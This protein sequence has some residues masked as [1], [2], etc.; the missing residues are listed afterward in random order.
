MNFP[1]EQLINFII[2]FQ[3]FL[4]ELLFAVRYP[5]YE[6]HQMPARRQSNQP[7]IAS[8]QTQTNYK[9]HPPFGLLSKK[10]GDTHFGD[11]LQR[12][13]NILGKNDDFRRFQKA[14]SNMLR[15]KNVDDNEK[16]TSTDCGLVVKNYKEKHMRRNEVTDE[17]EVD[18][19]KD[20]DRKIQHL[21]RIRTFRKFQKALDSVMNSDN[22]DSGIGGDIEPIKRRVNGTDHDDSNDE[23]S[24]EH[25]D[26]SGEDSK[27]SSEGSGENDSK[28]VE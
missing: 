13:V 11:W 16:S 2:V 3:F 8:S 10:Q 1:P 15:R 6:E 4:V 9:S 14:E 7:E 17:G 18:D 12:N 20:L 19:L 5:Q 23:T 26:E 25:S 28:K 22:I 21:I 27:D 24:G